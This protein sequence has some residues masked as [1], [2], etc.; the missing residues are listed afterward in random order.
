MNLLQATAHVGQEV[1]DPQRVRHVLRKVG[2]STDRVRIL[3]AWF[4]ETFLAVTSKQIAILNIGADW[5]ESLKLCLD[6]FYDRVVQG[7]FI[8]LDD[9]GHW[10]SCKKAADEFFQVRNLPYKLIPVNYTACWFQKA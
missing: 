1:G 4:Q 2:A 10:P 9:Y 6:M 5:Y 8:S 7:E 3:P